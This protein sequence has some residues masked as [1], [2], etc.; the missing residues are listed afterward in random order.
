M[1]E[2]LFL[3]IKECRIIGYKVA[4]QRRVFS[5]NHRRVDVERLAW[6]GSPSKMLPT[7]PYWLKLKLDVSILVSGQGA[8]NQSIGQE[9]C[10]SCKSYK[11]VVSN[12]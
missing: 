12:E 10:K 1:K 8:R 7:I 11:G 3:S 5:L 9:K 2:C 4:V 6:L